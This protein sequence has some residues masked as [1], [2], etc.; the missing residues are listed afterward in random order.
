MVCL[1]GFFGCGKFGQFDVM[2]GVDGDLSG[3]GIVM[4]GQCCVQM[5]GCGDCVCFMCVV[6]VGVQI[7][8]LCDMFV[9]FGI[10]QF[11]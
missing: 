10:V 8:Q 4:V 11:F 7:F 2:C 5:V 3:I 9:E 1:C 6:E